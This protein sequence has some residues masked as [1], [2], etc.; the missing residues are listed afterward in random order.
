[1][2][3][4]ADKEKIVFDKKQY[5]SSLPLIK[6]QLKALVARDLWDM[7]EYFEIMNQSNNSVIRALEVLNSNEYQKLLK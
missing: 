6:M 1:M 7:N 3:E 5:E 2:K 4:L